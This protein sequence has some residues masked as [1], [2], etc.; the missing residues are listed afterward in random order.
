MLSLVHGSAPVPEVMIVAMDEESYNRLGQSPDKL[1]DRS[2]HAQLV[3]TLLG[4][5]ARAV[6]FDVFFS[7]EWPDPQA[8]I[9]LAEA[10]QRAAGKVV[11][12]ASLPTFEVRG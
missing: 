5:G 11:L 10:L 2:R 9:R 12:G 6:V 8:D 4:R 1:W 3:E 7:E